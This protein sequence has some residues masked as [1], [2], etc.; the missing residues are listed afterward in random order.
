MKLITSISGIR[1]IYGKTLTDKIASLYVHSFVDIQKDGKI[2]L[3]QDT[4][5]HGK[6]L[7]KSISKTLTS[8]GRD[9]LSCGIIPTPTAQY[10]I[11][12]KN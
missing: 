7:Y 4:R 11:K 5:P 1:G 9:V 10:I 6:N 2:L 3:A 12:E 8:V